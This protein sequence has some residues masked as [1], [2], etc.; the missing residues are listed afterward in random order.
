MELQV[1]WKLASRAELKVVNPEGL[2]LRDAQQAGGNVS[3]A[4]LGMMTCTDAD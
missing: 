1:A 2:R 3:R 4:P